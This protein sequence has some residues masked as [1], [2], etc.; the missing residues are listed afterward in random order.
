MA[1][2]DYD[3]SDGNSTNNSINDIDENLLSVRLVSNFEGLQFKFFAN[4]V[5]YIE[6]LLCI[7]GHKLYEIGPTFQIAAMRRI[8]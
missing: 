7:P 1:A 4:Q 6:V 3:G 8:G 5:L 2:F